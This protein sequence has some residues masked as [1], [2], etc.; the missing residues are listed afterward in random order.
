VRGRGDLVLPPG[1]DGPGARAL[2]RPEG[3]DLFGYGAREAVVRA[4]RGDPA[5]QAPFGAPVPA[6]ELA[7]T[8]R[9]V[10]GIE[11]APGPDGLELVLPPGR[12]SALAALAFAH[13]W[14][15]D[16]AP[17]AGPDRTDQPVVVGLR[18]GTP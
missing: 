2:V 12:V 8:V 10:L 14:E 4:L 7:A 16:P 9:D 11:A 13:G 18:P 5:D 6:A 15:V 3:A 17:A 1:D